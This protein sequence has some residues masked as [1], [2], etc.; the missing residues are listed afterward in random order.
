MAKLKQL[1]TIVIHAEA[2]GLY[3]RSSREKPNDE[4]ENRMASTM[5]RWV[6]MT[7]FGKPVVPDV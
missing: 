6:K 5:P 3:K 2:D 1:M 7:P 4:T